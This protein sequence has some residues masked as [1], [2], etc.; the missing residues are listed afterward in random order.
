MV[1]MVLLPGAAS[2]RRPADVGPKRERKGKM[3]FMPLIIQ[4]ELST[5]QNT[6]TH[7]RTHR[8]THNYKSRQQ[9]GL[10]LAA[11]F[12]LRSCKAPP[13]F[14]LIWKLPVKI[15]LFISALCFST[16]AIKTENLYN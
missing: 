13:S 4:R 9:P 2:L 7:Q 1:L 12:S 16:L 11:A 5:H 6:P 3:R 8:Q 15:N 14:I 10:H